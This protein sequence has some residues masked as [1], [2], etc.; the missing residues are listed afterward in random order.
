MGSPLFGGDLIAIQVE[1]EPPRK[2]NPG[3]LFSFS[4]QSVNRRGTDIAAAATVKATLPT[5]GLQKRC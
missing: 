3:W 4:Q 5:G 2:K 1:I